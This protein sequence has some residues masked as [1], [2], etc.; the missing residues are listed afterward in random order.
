[1]GPVGK[2]EQTKGRD[3]KPVRCDTP[4]SSAQGM[5]ANGAGSIHADVPDVAR[6]PRIGLSSMVNGRP[7]RVKKMPHRESGN[8][9][10]FD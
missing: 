3:K 6:H 7:G 4:K 1:M 10:H 5:S 8:R 9:N 2:C